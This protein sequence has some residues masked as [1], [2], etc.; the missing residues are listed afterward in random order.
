MASITIKPP[1][2]AP[3]S[4]PKRGSTI[5][6][7]GKHVIG[8]IT[9]I[10]TAFRRPQKVI[11]QIRSIRDRY[12]NLPIIVADNGDDYPDLSSFDNVQLL[13]LPF[14]SGIAASRNAAI[15]HVQTP[16]V[17]LTDDDH[18]FTDDSRLEH[19]LSVLN[20]DPSIGVVGGW[21]W[22]EY[23]NHRSAWHL[24]LYE[25]G[26]ELRADVA[27]GP[28]RITREG[29]PHWPCDTVL[30]FALARREIYDV[31]P[32]ADQLKMCEHWEW[33]WRFKKLNRWRV[34]FC[35]WFG[36]EHHPY[37]RPA[38]YD[39]YR[40]RQSTFERLSQQLHGLHRS[41]EFPWRQA[42]ATPAG[43]PN[44]IILTPGHTGSSVTTAMIQQ[45]GWLLPPD[46][47]HYAESPECRNINQYMQ[48]L[49]TGDLKLAYPQSDC[50][51]DKFL[52][53]LPQ[54][55]VLKDPR[56]C[57]TLLDWLLELEPY[58]PTLVYLTRMADD[59]AVSYA[60]RGED[61]AIGERRLRDC[62][63]IYNAW[64]WPRI[65]LDFSQ[66][67]SAIHLFRSERIGAGTDGFA[68]V[69]T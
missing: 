49:A 26:A 29:V 23:R 38:G 7:P 41:G 51:R 67:Q 6:V 43:R 21:L 61:P 45:L 12:P 58:A 62:R 64:P 27:R 2:P 68:E 39:D 52:K 65:Q 33:M 66:L 63:H 19:L 3:I 35:P 59:I 47:D 32:W 44:L 30:N 13:K 25:T 50:R 40:Y 5:P 9:V 16:L 69:A 1:K 15:A 10:M 11:E 34:A 17:F 48:D 28:V 31:C 22:E 55:W 46:A 18:L 20:S 54:P 57:E 14:D 8:D 24:N 36:G 42:N 60:R 4:V 56:F 37:P 53:S